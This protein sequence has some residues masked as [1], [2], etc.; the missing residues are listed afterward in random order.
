MADRYRYWKRKAI[1]LSTYIVKLEEEMR[2]LE[3]ASREM[4]DRWRE[5]LDCR[6]D[7]CELLRRQLKR[8]RASS[9]SKWK[10]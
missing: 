8:L 6:Q 5:A 7:E 10:G 1:T 9:R 4:S 2:K 3:F